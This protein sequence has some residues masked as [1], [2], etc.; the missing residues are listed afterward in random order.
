MNNPITNNLVVRFL[1][2]V[3]HEIL[4][5]TWPTRQEMLKWLVVVIV[6]SLIMAFYVGVIDLAFTK[7]LEYILIR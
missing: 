1:I 7:V 5:V 4:K 3:Y 2:E 6:I